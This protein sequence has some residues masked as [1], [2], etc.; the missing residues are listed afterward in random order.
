MK[1][2][3]G[4]ICTAHDHRARRETD[5]WLCNPDFDAIMPS[6][7]FFAMRLCGVQPMAVNKAGA[8]SSL[9]HCKTQLTTELVTTYVAQ[10]L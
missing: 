3:C 5:G 4:A 2:M 7:V 6:I 9:L 10:L 1:A 8:L